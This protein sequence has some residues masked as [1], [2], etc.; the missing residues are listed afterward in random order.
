MA[1]LRSY[2]G[3]QACG[4]QS[5]KYLLSDPLRKKFADFVLKHEK[6]IGR[7]RLEMNALLLV[8][9]NLVCEFRKPFLD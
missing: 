2:E 1:V 7:L 9:N 6:L 3:D 8:Y 4:S 5:L